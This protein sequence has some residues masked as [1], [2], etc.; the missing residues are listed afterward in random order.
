[1]QLSHSSA[2]KSQPDMMT[3]KE[4]SEISLVLLKHKSGPTLSSSVQNTAETKKNLRNSKWNN[5]GNL[6][7]LVQPTWTHCS[8]LVNA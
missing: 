4:K 8:R 5:D 6:Q 2:L 7:A 3:E 1:M